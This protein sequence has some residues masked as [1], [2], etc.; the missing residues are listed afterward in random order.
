MT[1]TVR[2]RRF[3]LF[4]GGLLLAACP[5]GLVMGQEAAEWTHWRGPEQNGISRETNLV[6]EWSL[7]PPKNVSWQSDVGGRATPVIMNGRVFLNCRTAD[8]VVDP[9]TKINAREQVICWDLNTGEELWRDIFNVFQTDIPAPRVGWASMVGDKETGYVYVHSV[10][11]ILRCYDTEGKVI[12]EISLAEQYGKISGYGGRTQTPIIDEDRLIVSFM[13]TNWGSTKGPAPLHY[14]YSFDKKTG[15][16]QWVSAPGGAPKD[17]NYSVPVVAVINGQR[18]LIGGNCDGHVYSINARTGKPI[19]SFKMSRRGLNTTPVV[20]NNYVYISHGED[21]I[22]NTEFGRVQCIDATG[23]GDVTETH[24]VW[25]RDGI[26][27][28]YTALVVDNNIL[29]VV[30]DLGNMYAYDAKTGEDLWQHDLGTVG[31]GSPVLADGKIYATEV[32]GNMWILKPSKE[33]CETLSHVTIP[34]AVGSGMDEIYASCAI[35]NGNV[36]LVT[37]DRTVCI[38]DAS[39]KPVLNPPKPLPP[40]TGMKDV[41]DLIQVRPYE[42]IVKPGSE[43]EFEIH[44]FDSNGVSLG[45]LSDGQFTLEGLDEFSVTGKV[46]KA[47]QVKKHFAGT[48]NAKVG[49]KTASGRVRMFSP[50]KQWKWDFEGYKPMQVPSHWVRAFAKLKPHQMEDGTVMKVTGGSGIKGRP[51]HQV[52]IGYPEMSDYEIQADVYLEEQRRQ[53]ASIGLSCNR[54]NLIL[55]GNVGKLMVQS[56][57]PHNRMAKE[58]KYRS[59]PGIWYT[60]KMKVEIT[61]SG[62]KVYGKVWKRGET[63]P[64]EWTVEASDPHPNKTGSPGLYFYALADCY[65]DN[66]IVTQ[67]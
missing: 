42:T 18:Q 65:F 17:T 66:V 30:A 49:D 27:A 40:E 64:T 1:T 9:E 55:R 53:L 12:W 37:R 54:Y 24:S 35:S 48:V 2:L 4:L 10:S 34:A 56:W 33:G 41:I 45:V 25:R 31:K 38:K 67:K 23:T 61:D 13:A 58:I 51:S 50:A 44:A 46:L 47:P 39:K 19:W 26:K 29:Y 32:N 15:D 60:M 52:G 36:V 22:D 16:L 28:G 5:F 63:E 62:A 43:T 11:G 57:A 6:E 3:S 8:D 20:A 7:D 21:N 14:Y 59:D